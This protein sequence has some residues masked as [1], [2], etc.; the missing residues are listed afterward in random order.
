MESYRN[1]GIEDLNEQQVRDIKRDAAHAL[2]R[3]SAPGSAIYLLAMGI[4]YFSTA[5]PNDFPDLFYLATTAIMIMMGI[6]L[7]LLLRFDTCYDVNPQRWSLLKGIVITTSAVSLSSITAVA[8]YHYPNSWAA[9][10]SVALSIGVSAGGMYSMDYKRAYMYIFLATLLLP[11][12]VASALVGGT[13]GILLAV[14]YGLFLMYLL[15]QSRHIHRAFWVARINAIRHDQETKQRLHQL[16]YH[17]AV[18]EL[19]NRE[20]F[21]DRLQHELHT[22][23]RHGKMTA[24]LVLGLDRFSNINDTLGH[25]TGDELL[26]AVGVRL[27]SCLRNNDTISRY[28]SDVFAIVLSNLKET[29]DIARIANKLVDA[30]NKP[31]SVASI[32]VFVTASIGISVAPLDTSK[33]EALFRNAEATMHRVK[34]FGGNTHQFYE[35]SI[36]AE[37]SERLQLEAKLR[38]A[39]EK[40]EYRLFYQPKVDLSTGEL[41]GFEALLRWCPDN[42]SPI[43]PARFI[44][45]LE[46][47]GLIV[48]VGEWVLRSACQQAM[49]WQHLNFK[50]VRMAVNLSARQFR[51][52]NLVQVTRQILQ[53]TGLPAELLEFE[54]TESML[55]EDTEHTINIL[56]ELNS[57]GIRLSIDDFGTGYSSLAYLKRM[58]IHTLKIDRSFVKDITTDNDDASVVETI[59]AMAHNLRLRVVAEGTETIEQIRFLRRQACDE[60]QGYYFSKPLPAEDI[61]E[62]LQTGNFELEQTVPKKLMAQ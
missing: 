53:Q 38:R 18:T 36:N 29:R 3:R 49:A 43:S 47:T 52:Q 44:P 32:E 27:Q 54:I 37:T 28:G 59:I 20:L 13:S 41:C 30:L 26:R 40:N 35:A 45:I 62:I 15:D 58:P 57:M 42:G 8:I 25:Q 11:N 50:P 2:A 51:D 56:N 61:R 12:L 19:P 39:L 33:P 22:A 24:V 5:I 1:Q 17:D 10:V 4:Y 6:R 34:Q 23:E 31:F 16:T 48:P 7:Y 60:T 14:L 21:N 55:M 46:E 9:Q